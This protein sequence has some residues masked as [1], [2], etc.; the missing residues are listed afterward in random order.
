M[1]IEI[2]TRKNEQDLLYKSSC[3]IKALISQGIIDRL[4]LFIPFFYLSQ[5][6]FN[7]G[8]NKDFS[9]I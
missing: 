3:M 4:I 9:Y 2:N 7:A 6:T 1:E 8:K 5:K